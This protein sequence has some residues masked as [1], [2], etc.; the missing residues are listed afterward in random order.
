VRYEKGAQHPAYLRRPTA[1]G[2]DEVLFD[3]DAEAKG[4]AYYE[5]GAVSHAPDHHHLAYGYDDKGSEFHTL[6]IRAT[7][8][9]E[10][11]PEIIESASGSVAWSRDGRFLFY[12]V[13]DD[14]HRP[15]KVFRHALGTAVTEDVLVHE[16][17]D[18]GFFLGV[19][20]TEGRGHIVIDSHD[21]TTSE[22]RVIPGDDPTRAP[23]LVQ[24]RQAGVEYS[25]AEQA[26]RFVILTNAGDAED[27]KIVS[28]PIATPQRDHWTDEVGHEP[29]RLI[30]AV[31]TYARYSV[32]LERVQ[33]LPRIVVRALDGQE[34]AIAFDEEAYS[35]GLSGGWEYDTDIVRFTYSSPTTPTRT[36]DYDM[37]AR[38]RTLLKE[39]QIPSGHDPADYRCARALAPA[40][41]GERV[42]V[43]LL[44]RAD[45][46]L[47][48]SAPCLLYGYGSYGHALPAAFRTV[49]LSL[50]DRGFVYAMAHVRGGKDKGYA[51]YRRGKLLEKKNTFTDFIAAAEHLVAQGY[52]S[53][54]E[55]T[56][57]GG[58][59]GGML[60]GVAANLRPELW[61]AV[62]GEVPFVDVLTTMCDADLPL[63]P[64]E[65]PEWGNPIEDRQAYE[66]IAS[67]S[68]YDNVVAQDYP[69][70][71]AT[72][73]L[74]DPRVTYWEPAK[75]VARLRERRTNDRLLL[76]R[77]YMEA[78]HAGAA[79]RFNKLREDAFTYAFI[80]LAHDRV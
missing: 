54:G 27:F 29:G 56:I 39:Q 19:A 46:P 12:V 15:C 7:S 51:W 18:P 53:A 59:A 72:A 62:V 44:W 49:P 37:K 79:G 10:D 69:H 23:Q 67:Y 64:P 43:T 60:V 11:L 58:S 30:L 42:P 2:P 41:D 35:L 55:I 40:P 47:D 4:H 50:V 66:Y 17:A 78:G 14:Q 38:T 25:I 1:G 32:R 21:H 74:T 36:F 65:W 16:E 77:T 52:A 75:W 76:L 70:I 61:R 34:H 71:L 9:G 13:L 45:T 28:A 68:P 3:A 31:E 8:T 6:R 20:T 48:G 33:G 5:V 63:T 26:G 57:E 73:G 80:L 22:A 24:P